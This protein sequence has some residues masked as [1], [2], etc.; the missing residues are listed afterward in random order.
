MHNLSIISL[1]VSFHPKKIADKSAFS[2]FWLEYNTHCPVMT[3]DQECGQKK[4][5]NVDSRCGIK[6]PFTWV[7][8]L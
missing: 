4:K 6:G 8:K 2:E 7:S 3:E 1:H 5:K